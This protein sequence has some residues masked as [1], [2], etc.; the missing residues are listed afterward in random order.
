LSSVEPEQKL[1]A[2]IKFI[3]HSLAQ[4]MTTKIHFDKISKLLDLLD[5]HIN[6]KNCRHTPKELL[7]EYKTEMF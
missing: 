7:E 5:R 1:Q 3:V 2:F 4:P 6:E